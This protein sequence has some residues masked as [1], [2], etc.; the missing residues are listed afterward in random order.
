MPRGA[1]TI[2]C[3]NNIPGTQVN[4]F[5]RESK[6]TQTDPWERQLLFRVQVPTTVFLRRDPA[7][8]AM[9]QV[10]L[11]AGVETAACEN[12]ATEQVAPSHGPTSQPFLEAGISFEKPGMCSSPVPEE[13]ADTMYEAFWDES[14]LR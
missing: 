2:Q 5:I 3:T 7:P 14:F 10:S 1:T 11:S 8:A 6:E 9:K 12:F 4:L 13:P